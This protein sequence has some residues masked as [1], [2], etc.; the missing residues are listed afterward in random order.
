MHEYR[1][2]HMSICRNPFLAGPMGGSDHTQFA[3]KTISDIT[4]T[5][6]IYEFPNAIGSG[7]DTS[8]R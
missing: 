6:I 4:A 1:N 3:I 7:R 8:Q 2:N 5:A